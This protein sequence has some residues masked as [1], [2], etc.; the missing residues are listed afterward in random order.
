[1][2]END[3]LTIGVDG[4]LQCPDWVFAPPSR[5]RKNPT[6]YGFNGHRL[7]SVTPTMS[8]YSTNDIL[9]WLPLAAVI[10]SRAAAID[11]Q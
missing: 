5:T 6:F 2:P 8:W 10:V 11:V 1:M 9:E 3:L 4:D 7:M